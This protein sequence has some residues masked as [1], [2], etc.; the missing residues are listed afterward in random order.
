VADLLVAIVIFGCFSALQLLW[1][2]LA[3]EIRWEMRILRLAV[4]SALLGAGATLL[5][6]AWVGWIKL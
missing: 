5:L 6:L 4:H 3:W 1:A 2:V